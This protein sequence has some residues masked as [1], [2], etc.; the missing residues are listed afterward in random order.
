[1]TLACLLR[2]TA[3][4]DNP[5]SKASKAFPNSIRREFKKQASVACVH[6]KAYMITNDACRGSLE[7]GISPKYLHSY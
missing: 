2:A 6:S 7:S 4:S 5:A 1:M 3:S